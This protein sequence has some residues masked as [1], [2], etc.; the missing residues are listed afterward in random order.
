VVAAT[1]CLWL[2]ERVVNDR[3]IDPIRRSDLE[4]FLISALILYLEL[5]LIRWI[6]TEI[7]IFAYLGNLILVVCFF[8]VGLGCYWAAKPVQTVKMAAYLLFLATVVANP[9]HIALLDFSK[10]SFLLSG[11]EDSFFAPDVRGPGTGYVAGCLVI[12]IIIYVLTLTFVPL[13]QILGRAM[14][15]APHVIRA[16]S[17]NITGSLAGVWLFNG[18]SWASTPPA[19]WMLVAAVL[20]AATLSSRRGARVAGGRLGDGGVLWLCGSVTC[21][22]ASSSGRPTKR[23]RCSLSVVDQ[24]PPGHMPFLRWR[25]DDAPTLFPTVEQGL[26]GYGVKVN[27]VHSDHYIMDLSDRFL[28]LHPG[29]FPQE[30]W[31]RHPLQCPLQL[32]AERAPHTDCRRRYRQ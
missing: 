29:M 27:G 31:D 5:L 20:L 19:V 14:Q 7:R 9:F 10:V 8:G 4:I 17:V 32:Q 23:S 1:R 26:P 22:L 13:G 2:D 12:G 15:R 16:Y 24:G 6:G 28:A 30:R 11:F 3:H 25:K 21:P 18:L